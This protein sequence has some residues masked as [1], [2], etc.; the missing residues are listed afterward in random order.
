MTNI[1]Y[2]IRIVEV[3]MAV[4]N[5]KVDEFPMKLIGS[6][7]NGNICAFFAKCRESQVRAF[8]KRTPISG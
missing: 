6:P 2:A 7:K 4:M 3:F 8:R 5:T 1:R